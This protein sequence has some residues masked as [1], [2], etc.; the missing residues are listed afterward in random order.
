MNIRKEEV[1]ILRTLAENYMEIA[2]LPVQREKMELW[3]AFNRHD[4]VR[5]MVLID[6]LPWNELNQD[7][8]LTCLTKD[9][10][11]R[12]IEF[13]LRSTIYQWKHFPADM[14]VEPFLTIPF[15]T[16]NSGWGLDVEEEVAVT[17]QTNSVVSHAYKNQLETEED[18]EKIKDMEITLNREESAEWLEAASYLF[19]GI[20]PVRQAGGAFVHLGI[21]DVLAERMGVENIYFDLLDR[22]D[23]IH[24]IMEKMT[25]SALAG[26]HQMNE[27]GLVDTSENHCHC[28]MIYNEEQLPDFGAGVGSDTHH[29]WGF[30]MAQLFTSVSPEMTEEFEVPYISRLAQEY[31]MIYY[32]CC[33]RLDDR[34]EIVQRIPHVKKLSC[35]P[36]SDREAFAEKLRKD[37]VM[38]N[39]PTPAF[40]A[41]D[42]LNCGVVKADLERT[43]RA[44]KRNGI[45]L[46]MILKDISTVRYEPQ[47][48]TEWE[49]C[50]MKVAESFA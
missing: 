16:Q 3:K 34:I 37:I 47:R 22:P 48:L 43:C 10:F 18:L 12:G 14:V 38:S 9:P 7:G 36:W 45:A 40:L 41:A 32:G 8:E 4:P 39:K 15:S 24:K 29:A 46:E 42:S 27:L 50:A 49:R 11:L 44:A 28:S 13:Q 20:L 2:T 19:D 5:P 17:D 33:D 35:S 6:Q 26:I 21:W 31:Q 25:H 30:G 23:F 1:Q